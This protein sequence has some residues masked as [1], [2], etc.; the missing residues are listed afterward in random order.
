MQIVLDDAYADDED[1]DIISILKSLHWK[2]LSHSELRKGLSS[3]IKDLQVRPDI[4]HTNDL[5]INHHVPPLQTCLT[6]FSSA[7]LMLGNAL[8]NHL[9]TFTFHTF[10]IET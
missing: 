7:A 3:P 8:H 5:L 4:P 2:L 1:N 9:T 10:L 6:A